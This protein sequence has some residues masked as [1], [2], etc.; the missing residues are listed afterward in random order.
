VGHNGK[1]NGAVRN[2]QTT[3]IWHDEEF[4]RSRTLGNRNHTRLNPRNVARRVSRVGC[5]K[6]SQTHRTVTGS[7]RR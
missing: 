2:M 5:V 3:V 7:R 4:S 6:S 1:E